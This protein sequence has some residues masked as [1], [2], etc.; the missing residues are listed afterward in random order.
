MSSEFD[1]YATDYAGGMDNPVKSLLGESA[2]A[3][4]AVKLRWM[5]RQFPDLRTKDRN[6]RV[7]DYG[8]GIATLLRLMAEDGLQ[9]TLMGCDVAGN[10]LDEAARRWPPD[11]RAPELHHQE[12]A[13]TPLPD[14]SVDLV[15]ISA[16][17]HHIALDDRTAVYAELRR[18]LR[19]NGRVIVFE[20]NPLNPVT[21]YVVAHTPIDQN[22]ILL[23]AGE[24]SAALRQMQ[25]ADV[26]TSYL[27]FLPPRLAA[28]A[29]LE[30]LIKWLPLGAQY[31]T[32]AKRSV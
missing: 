12:G 17:L 9:A 27:M 8:C 4:V 19:P 25:F 21:R 32:T 3:F 24:V 28:L 22:A 7:L 13:R 2:D 15:I 6:F 29:A 16:V 14:G 31:A 10:M 23:R 11:L 20:H 26:R 18:L 30:S 1:A 5:L